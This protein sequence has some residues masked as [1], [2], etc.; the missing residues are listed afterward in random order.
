MLCIYLFKL[1]DRLVKGL[2]PAALLLPCAAAVVVEDE[3]E[4]AGAGTGTGA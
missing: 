4:D 2:F 3:D 1:G